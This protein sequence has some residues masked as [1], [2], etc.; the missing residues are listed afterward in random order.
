[1]V[2]ACSDSPRSEP[3]TVEWSTERARSVTISFKIPLARAIAQ[4]Q[5]RAEDK[6]LVFEMLLAE[7][8]QPFLLDRSGQAVRTPLRFQQIHLWVTEH[9]QPP[10]CTGSRCA[11]RAR[12]DQGS[13]DATSTAAVWRSWPEVDPCELI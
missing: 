11:A 3:H 8:R 10:S 9:C 4:V 2:R 13:S 12:S 1:M 6:D 7:Q 5:S